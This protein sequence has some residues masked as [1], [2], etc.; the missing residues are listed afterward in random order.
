MTITY[1][2]NSNTINAGVQ[3]TWPP[4]VTGENADATQKINATWYAHLWRC[5]TMEMVEFEVLE[6][7]KGSA[8]AEL[9]TTD[10]D[11]PNSG[12]TY[13][14][15][16]IMNVTGRQVGRRMVNVAVRFLVDVTS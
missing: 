14:T 9:K 11:T 2:V 10:Q 5:D 4:I 1:E 16:R 3:A 7:L 13:S 12:N 15:G 6:P 8:L